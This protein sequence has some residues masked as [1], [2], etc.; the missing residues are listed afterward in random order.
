LGGKK[1]GDKGA[2]SIPRPP[3]VKHVISRIPLDREFK[4]VEQSY[5]GDHLDLILAIGYLRRLVANP[6]VAKFLK[7]AKKPATSGDHT[8]KSGFTNQN[9]LAKQRKAEEPKPVTAK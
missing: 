3:P 6:R 5:G 4:L 9:C 7:S 1:G 2:K 8:E